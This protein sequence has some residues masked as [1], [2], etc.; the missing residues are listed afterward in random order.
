MTY[1][2]INQTYIDDIDASDLGLEPGRFPLVLT[3]DHRE[4]ILDTPKRNPQYELEAYHYVP[5]EDVDYPLV[6][7]VWND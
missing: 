3:Y 6:L 1:D 2:T 5:R 7:C 4:W